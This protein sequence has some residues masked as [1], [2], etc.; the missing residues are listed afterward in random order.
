MEKS[1]E[2]EFFPNLHVLI[3]NVE[4]NA[5]YT[6]LNVESEAVELLAE[7]DREIEVHPHTRKTKSKESS[8]QLPKAR[9]TLS[10]ELCQVPSLFS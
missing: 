2:K 1:A 5:S 7:K 9:G 8:T 10:R 3:N 4:S 6:A